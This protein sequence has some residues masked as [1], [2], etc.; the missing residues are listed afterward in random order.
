MMPISSPAM[1]RASSP[2]TT[3]RTVRASASLVFARLSPVSRTSKNTVGSKGRS[4][5]AIASLSPGSFTPRFVTSN[6]ARHGRMRDQLAVIEHSGS[7]LADAF[8]HAVLNAQRHAGACLPRMSFHVVIVQAFEVA[9]EG[10]G[11]S[12]F[13]RVLTQDEGRK[14]FLVAHEDEPFRE[15]QRAQDGRNGQLSRLVD[16]GDIELPGRVIAAGKEKII[17]I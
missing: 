16:N 4:A 13:C 1:P 8:I 3:S 11:Q 14:L 17:G 2:A 9:E 15:A 7:K 6:W 10:L 12:L 5:R